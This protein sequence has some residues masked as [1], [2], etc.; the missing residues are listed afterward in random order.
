MSP[1]QNIQR[2]LE[3]NLKKREELLEDFDRQDSNNSQGQRETIKQLAYVNSMIEACN[4]LIKS[5]KGDV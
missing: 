1:L 4:Y 2:I 5:L 3:E